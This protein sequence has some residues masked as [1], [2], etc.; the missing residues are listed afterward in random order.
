MKQPTPGGVPVKTTSPGIRVINLETHQNHEEIP[1]V[2]SVLFKAGFML[3]S[4]SNI[5]T[6]YISILTMAIPIWT[7]ITL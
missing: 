6:I 2:K 5:L 7:S 4:I 3:T 1:V